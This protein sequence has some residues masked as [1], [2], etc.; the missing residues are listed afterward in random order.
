MFKVNTSWMN[1]RDVVII[2]CYN[3]VAVALFIKLLNSLDTMLPE[4]TSL[5]CWS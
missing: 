3:N 5:V 4:S 2:V 1:R